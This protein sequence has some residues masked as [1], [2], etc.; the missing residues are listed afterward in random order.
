MNC[1]VPRPNPLSASGYY[2]KCRKKMGIKGKGYYMN[3]FCCTMHTSE[4]KVLVLQTRPKVCKCEGLVSSLYQV[5]YSGIYITLL[6]AMNTFI[7]AATSGL[8]LK[9]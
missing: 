9:L 1:L 2:R 4:P 5:W 8:N 7:H 6:T 3:D